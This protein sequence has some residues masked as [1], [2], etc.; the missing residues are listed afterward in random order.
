MIFQGK[1]YGTFATN[2]V[3]KF[4]FRKLNLNRV[5]LNVFSDN[6][7]AIRLYEKYGFVFEGKFKQH[8]KVKGILKDLSWYAIVKKQLIRYKSSVGGEKR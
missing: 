3:L 5:Y 6:T 2:E 1:G 4:A 7:N 8:L